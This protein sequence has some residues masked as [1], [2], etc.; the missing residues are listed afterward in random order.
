MA[1]TLWLKYEAV[2]VS[3]GFAALTEQ[4]MSD[5]RRCGARTTSNEMIARCS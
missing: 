2:C 1:R 5:N 4:I 3:V